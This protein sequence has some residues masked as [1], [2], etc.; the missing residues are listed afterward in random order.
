MAKLLNF[1]MVMSGVYLLFYFTGL[2]SPESSLL[3]I[4]L[5]PSQ[6]SFSSIVTQALSVFTLVGLST[7]VIGFVT[8][9]YE[10][11]AMST[12]TTYLMNLMWGFWDVYNKFAESNQILSILIFGPVF[13]VFAITLVYFWRGRD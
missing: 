3:T 5:N 7:V 4:L 6:I 12:F 8:K 2:I 1:I 10:L 13:I 11:V 9:N